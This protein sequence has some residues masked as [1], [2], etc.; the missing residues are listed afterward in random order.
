[1]N[2]QTQQLPF[3]VRNKALLLELQIQHSKAEGKRSW[4][5]D[6]MSAHAELNPFYASQLEEWFEDGDTVFLRDVLADMF[7]SYFKNSLEPCAFFNAWTSLDSGLLRVSE[8]S[9]SLRTA[10]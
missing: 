5:L 1:M 6:K 4:L 2:I 3:S 8:N 9:I 7:R 10:A